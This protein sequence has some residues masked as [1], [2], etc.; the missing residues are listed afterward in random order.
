LSFHAADILEPEGLKRAVAEAATVLGP[1]AVV[2]HFAGMAHAGM[3]REQP[4]RAFALNVTG[5]LHVLEACRAAGLRRV[6]FPS[7]ALVYGTPSRLPVEEDAAPAPT[8]VYA[9]TKAAAEALLAGHAG[10]F[11]F[12][13][14]IARLGNVYGPGAA[15]DSIVSILLRQARARERLSVR[16][17][18]PVR[19]FIFSEDVV[20]GLVRLASAGDEAGCRVFNL[21]SG[22]ATSIRELAAAVCRTTGIS[23]EVEEREPASSGEAS[24]LVLSIR[25]LTER[26][27]WRPAVP[28]GDGIRET[29]AAMER[30]QP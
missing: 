25:R 24:R 16:T 20:E 17:A 23:G 19:D 11:G 26:T 9:A 10:E 27:G 4:L 3:C 14:D 2:F 22:E 30:E 13:C 5:T 12:S 8:S 1:E 28:L 7:T 15:T 29:L 18:S 6:V 21:S